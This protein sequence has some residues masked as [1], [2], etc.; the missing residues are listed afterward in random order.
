[1]EIPAIE[2]FSFLRK[3]ERIVSGRVDLDPKSPS[4]IG[5]GIP[6]CSMNLRNATE[7]IGILNL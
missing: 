4:N 6:H 1:M 3:D 5:K 2:D 7:G